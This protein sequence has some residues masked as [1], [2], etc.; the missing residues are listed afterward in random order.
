MWLLPMHNNDFLLIILYVILVFIASCSQIMLKHATKK[1]YVSKWAEYLNPFVLL[2]YALFLGTTLGALALLRYLPIS[3]ASALEAAS[4]IF[5]PV[6]S[7]VV[8]KE[9][10][11]RKKALGIAFI[12]LGIVI[13]VM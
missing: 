8:L 10:I 11:G 6:L 1:V 2:A 4:H 12:T 13:F 7:F 9:S 3:V 5:V